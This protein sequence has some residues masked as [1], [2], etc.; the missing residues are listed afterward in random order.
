MG[1]HLPIMPIKKKSRSRTSNRKGKRK[2]QKGLLKLQL[3]TKRQRLTRRLTCLQSTPTLL[4]QHLLI[5][6][7]LYNVNTRNKSKLSHR[8]EKISGA[9]RSKHKLSQVWTSNLRWVPRK[10]TLTLPIESLREMKD[11]IVR[12]VAHEKA[13]SIIRV[14][15]L[16]QMKKSCESCQ[17]T[18]DL[19]YLIEELLKYQKMCY[20]L[21]NL[22]KF[23]FPVSHKS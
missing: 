5:M 13:V 22:L 2:V 3:Q 7:T 20:K 18:L 4:S 9:S 21:P 1:W 8:S 14:I 16:I 10:I 19:F 17:L 23:V 12:P 15:E 6:M 11:K